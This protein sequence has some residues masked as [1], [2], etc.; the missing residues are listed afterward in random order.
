MGH[1]LL[2][3]LVGKENECLGEE[4]AVVSIMVDG[5]GI[6]KMMDL[7]LIIEMAMVEA[8]VFPV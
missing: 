5:E 2:I 3:Q 4:I 1:N 8:K 7:D 6:A